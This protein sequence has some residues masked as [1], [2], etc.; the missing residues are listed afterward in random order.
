MGSAISIKRHSTFAQHWQR[1]SLK[2]LMTT[3]SYRVD[4]FQISQICES[5]TR[6][7]DAIFKLTSAPNSRNLNWLRSLRLPGC[8]WSDW[9]GCERGALLSLRQPHA[10]SIL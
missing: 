9:T 2:P 6:K 1:R 4:E 8:G 3:M 5:Q 10:N 7:R